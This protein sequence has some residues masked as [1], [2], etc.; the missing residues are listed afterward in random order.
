[1]KY[2]NT[3]TGI[4]ISAESPVCGEWEPVEKQ[5]PVVHTE[6]PE[7]PVRKKT[8]KTARKAV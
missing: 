2:R 8:K 6:E 1:M 3:K 7:K 4:I 5:A